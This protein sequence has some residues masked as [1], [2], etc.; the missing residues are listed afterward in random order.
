MRWLGFNLCLDYWL[1]VWALDVCLLCYV[2]LFLLVW[3][4]ILGVFVGYVVQ[5]RLLPCCNVVW[6]DYCWLI[7]LLFGCCLLR[8]FDGFFGVLVVCAFDFGWFMILIVIDLG[9]CLLRFGC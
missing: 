2:F 9:Y 6:L 5:L 8:A 3:K 1:F 7:T 4:L